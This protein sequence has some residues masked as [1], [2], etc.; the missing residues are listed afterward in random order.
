MT[1]VEYEYRIMMYVRKDM[2][3]AVDRD[4]VNTVYRQ[5]RNWNRFHHV[6]GKA[7]SRQRYVFLNNKFKQARKEALT[8]IK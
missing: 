6:F 4:G 7:C 3:R 1:M 2:F 5:A 8:F